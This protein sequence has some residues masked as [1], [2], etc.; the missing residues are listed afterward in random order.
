[1]DP[2]A[3]VPSPGLLF[4]LDESADWLLSLQQPTNV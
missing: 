3:S 2:D 4:T 1:M